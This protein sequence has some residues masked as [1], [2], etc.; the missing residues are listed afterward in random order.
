MTLMWLA[1]QKKN[2][3]KNIYDKGWSID[4]DSHGID[5][6][7]IDKYGYGRNG[8]AK[9]LTYKFEWEKKLLPQE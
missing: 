1:Q 7:K 9:K 2:L 3:A 8:R 4:V 6:H 5:K